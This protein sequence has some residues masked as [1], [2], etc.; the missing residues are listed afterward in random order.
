M[1]LPISISIGRDSVIPAMGRVYVHLEDRQ[2]DLFEY[3]IRSCAPCP[4]VIPLLERSMPLDKQWQF[5]LLAINPGMTPGQVAA[6]LDYRL[7]FTNG[8]GFGDRS[9]PRANWMTGENIGAALPQ[10]DKVRTCVRAALTGRESFSLVHALTQAVTLVLSRPTL[11]TARQSL[12]TLLTQNMLILDMLDGNLLPPLKSGK[13]YPSTVADIN[14]DDYL[15]NPREH[16]TKFFA[17]NIVNANG[18]VVQFP[19]GAL[20][21]WTGDGT[22]R[23]FMPHVSRYV[24]SWPLSRLRKLAAGERIPSPFRY[25]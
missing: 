1:T 18:E 19:N 15:Y 5:Y 17:A 6:K 8:T 23:V 20:Y 2:L 12:S 4:A 16:P 14:P 3:S 10:F 13:S 9:D 21:N 11:T 22:P 7:A 24:V 25:T